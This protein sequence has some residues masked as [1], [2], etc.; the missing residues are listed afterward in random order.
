M[1]QLVDLQY[2][3][4][5]GDNKIEVKNIVI[6]LFAGDNLMQICSNKDWSI[7]EATFIC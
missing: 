1:E 3:V 6:S 2:I 7:N 5:Y 4:K